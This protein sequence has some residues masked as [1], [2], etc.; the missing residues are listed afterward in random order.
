M[1]ANIHYGIDDDVHEVISA[2]EIV[3]NF[4]AAIDKVRYS[5]VSLYIT[6]GSQT[7]AELTPPPKS[8]FPTNKLGSLLNSLSSLGDDVASFSKDIQGIKD[9]SGIPEDP[10]ES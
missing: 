5:G 8:G 7:I 4:S 9:D 3:R 2:T 10:W 6:K 1:K